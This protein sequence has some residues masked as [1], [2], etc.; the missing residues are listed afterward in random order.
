[1]PSQVRSSCASTFTARSQHIYIIKA[2]KTSKSDIQS[3]KTQG[4]ADLIGVHV[5]TRCLSCRFG[6]AAVS[7]DRI[8]LCWEP[9]PGNTN[10]VILSPPFKARCNDYANNRLTPSSLFMSPANGVTRAYASD[11]E[12]LFRFRFTK[13]ASVPPGPRSR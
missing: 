11:R 6:I 12:S 1:M 9:W 7:A 10:V 13:L 5:F 2:K 4:R 8:M 3:V